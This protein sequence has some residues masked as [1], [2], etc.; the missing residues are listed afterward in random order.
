MLS[1]GMAWAAFFLMGEIRNHMVKP[2]NISKIW[3][4]DALA[5]CKELLFKIIEQGA[6][7]NHAKQFIK[8][9]CNRL[10]EQLRILHQMVA[11]LTYTQVLQRLRLYIINFF[12][13][14]LND[15]KLHSFFWHNT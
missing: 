15:L 12:V 3:S 6:A 14:P 7:F 10:I 1:G 2:S 13:C 11:G 9:T 4:S 8:E 5:G